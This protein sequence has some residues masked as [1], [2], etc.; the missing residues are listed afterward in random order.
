MKGSGVFGALPL[1][2]RTCRGWFIFQSLAVR[3]LSFSVQLLLMLRVYA[4]YGGNRRILK[5]LA[6]LFALNLLP[7][8]PIYPIVVP[9]LA[10]T[11]ACAPKTTPL[12]IFFLKFFNFWAVAVEAVLAI[13]TI[14]KCRQL[15]GS[16]VPLLSILVWDA[17]WVFVLILGS[18]EHLG[19]L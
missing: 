18:F 6:W 1:P 11:P 2:H 15:A 7:M 4:L 10:F 5:T 12:S 13:L 19:G 14:V 9:R 8:L 3:I 16:R 17:T